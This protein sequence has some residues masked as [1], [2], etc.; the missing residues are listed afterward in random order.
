MSSVLSRRS[1]G[2][3]LH[4][5]HSRPWSAASWPDRHGSSLLAF[6]V[7]P[8]WGGNTLHRVTMPAALGR[9]HGRTAIREPRTSSSL[10]VA[11]LLIRL[12]LAWRLRRTGGGGLDFGP[13][14]SQGGR[15][16]GH[17]PPGP[18]VGR[19]SQ[20]QLGYWESC[21]PDPWVVATL[22]RGYNIQFRRRPPIYSG[23]K[24]TIVNDPTKSQALR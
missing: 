1:R 15:G 10:I 14:E 21:S 2:S 18:A 11:E 13:P 19:F 5:L 22:S 24:M 12:L 20:Q 6:S 16:G 17:E 8:R 7:L 23:I 9:C 3:C 4:L